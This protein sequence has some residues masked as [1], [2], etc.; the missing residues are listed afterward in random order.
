[1]ATLVLALHFL[2]VAV[3]VVSVPLISLGGV[4]HWDWVRNRK[5]R[6]A[7]LAMMGIVTLEALF[8]ITCPLT[9][10]E[11]LLRKNVGE[12]GYERGFL[13]YW[14]QRLLYY[15]FEPW[16]FATVYVLFFLLMIILY[17]LVPPSPRSALLEK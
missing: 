9:L 11:N 10:W 3:V 1:M 2:W 14:L 15:D 4:L 8:S 13:D 5:F 6:H 7:H 16:I 17:R 12:S